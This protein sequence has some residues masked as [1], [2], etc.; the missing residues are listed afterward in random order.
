L[1]GTVEAFVPADI[2]RFRSDRNAAAGKLF[3]LRK[4][5]SGH[6]RQYRLSAGRRQIDDRKPSGT[7]AEASQNLTGFPVAPRSTLCRRRSA[8]CSGG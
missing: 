1:S 3:A 2:G 6:A 8:L 7:I 5:L 4:S